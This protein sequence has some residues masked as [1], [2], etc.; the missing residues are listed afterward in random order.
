ML[1]DN[2]Q[3]KGADGEQRNETLAGLASTHTQQHGDLGQREENA[4]PEGHREC[5]L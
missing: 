5:E 4:E 2:K 1:G 3:D